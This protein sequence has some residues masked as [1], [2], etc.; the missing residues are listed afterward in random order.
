MDSLYEVSQI[1]EVNREWAAQIWARIDSYMDKF[2]IEEGQDLLLDNILFLAVEIY[3]NAFLPKTIKE[4]EKNKNQLELLQ[5]LV[6]K[7][8]EK[9]SK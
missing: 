4:A 2:N 9:M 5:K 7:L 1:N 3:N 6:D 8:K